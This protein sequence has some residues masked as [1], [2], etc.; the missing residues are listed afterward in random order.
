MANEKLG[1]SIR[2]IATTLFPNDQK[3]GCRFPTRDELNGYKLR[4]FTCV[5]T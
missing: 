5:A 2:E 1:V 4:T 3:Q